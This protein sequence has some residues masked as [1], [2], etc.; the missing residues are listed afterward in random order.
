MARAERRIRDA[1]CADSLIQRTEELCKAY[2]GTAS[3]QRHAFVMVL[4]SRLVIAE[5]RLSRSTINALEDPADAPLSPPASQRSA[6][7]AGAEQGIDY[8]E[9]LAQRREECAAWSGDAPRPDARQGPWA[10]VV[11][12]LRRVLPR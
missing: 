5:H 8:A 9:V 1:M 3:R 7:A 4:I 10:R 2:E 12:T 6:E 11:R